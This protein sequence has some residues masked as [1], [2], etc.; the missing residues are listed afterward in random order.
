MM[1]QISM[2]T[3]V[4]ILEGM[5]VDKPKRKH[6]CRDD[7]VN[8]TLRR[9]IKRDQP[10]HER[11]KVLV[12]NAN[13]IGYRPLRIAILLAD[14]ASFGSEAELYEALVADD[15][16]LQAQKFLFVDRRASCF[17]NGAPPSLDT[18]L[19]RPLALDD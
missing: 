3:S 12:P 18:I 15:D 17:A 10:V 1:H 8:V 5:D 14:K 9:L 19:G 16:T 11:G 13:V 4:A 6:G 2:D 7:R